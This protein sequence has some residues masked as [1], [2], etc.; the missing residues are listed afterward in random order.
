VRR[1]DLIKKASRKDAKI[2]TSALICCPS[3]TD[4][5]TKKDK[6]KNYVSVE[7]NQTCN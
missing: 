4:F 1:N 5:L 7:R 2:K 6:E 3:K